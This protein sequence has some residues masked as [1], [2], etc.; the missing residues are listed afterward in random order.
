MAATADE[1]AQVI[2][3]MAATSGRTKNFCK[4]EPLELMKGGAEARCCLY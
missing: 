2:E 1:P 4:T 3:K